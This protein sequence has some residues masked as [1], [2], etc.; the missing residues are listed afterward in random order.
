MANNRSYLWLIILDKWTRLPRQRYHKSKSW[1][2]SNP[3]ATH[4]HTYEELRYGKVEEIESKQTIKLLQQV[5]DNHKDQE[6]K[7]TNHTI[8]EIKETHTWRLT[9]MV[10]LW[11]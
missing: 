8:R 5:E 7:E 3:K 6:A 11:G 1:L 10:R 2:I 4:T 9:W